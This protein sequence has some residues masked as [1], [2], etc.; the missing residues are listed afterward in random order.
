M[1]DGVWNNGPAKGEGKEVGPLQ[2]TTH[3]GVSTTGELPGCGQWNEGSPGGSQADP[4]ALRVGHLVW[5]K[6]PRV[7]GLE[8]QGS[9]WLT[10]VGPG[11]SPMPL[12][13]GGGRVGS[14]ER[15]GSC[16]YA[17]DFE[18]EG[19]ARSYWR[20]AVSRSWKRQ[21]REFSPRS[22]RGVLSGRPCDFSPGRLTGRPL[23][24]E[25]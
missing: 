8:M 1:G 5:Q 9:S 6:G 24:P 16:S 13:E 17:D 11:E 7:T 19:R 25:L 12:G 21:G 4:W 18:D 22:P 14:R 23:T 3:S 15:D 2:T 10:Q 20:K